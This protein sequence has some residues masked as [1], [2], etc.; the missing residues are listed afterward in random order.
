MST[1]KTLKKSDLQ[2][3]AKDAE[4]PLELFVCADDGNNFYRDEESLLDDFSESD[5]YVG[6]YKLVKVKRIVVP[7]ETYLEDVA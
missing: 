6:V 5:S 3:A 4:L 1:K 2:Q 7:E